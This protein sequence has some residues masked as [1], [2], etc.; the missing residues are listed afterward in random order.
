M[1]E[2]KANKGNSLEQRSVKQC[3]SLPL[4]KQSGSVTTSIEALQPQLAQEESPQLIKMAR[5][6]LA[7]QAQRIN[8]LSA[9]LEAAMLELKAIA[10]DLK[11]EQRSI[12]PAQEPIKSV[13]EYSAAV[14]PCV[15]RKKGGAFV[16][17]TRP[18]DL[19]RAEREATHVAQALRVRAKRK[20]RVVLLPTQ[21][22]KQTNIEY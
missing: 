2:L 5:Q 16:L 11:R 20:R 6:R 3:L 8:E 17:T 18:V 19:F 10:N 14:V 21:R 22:N 7:A 1:K 12:H 13:C 4:V 15:K 9:Q